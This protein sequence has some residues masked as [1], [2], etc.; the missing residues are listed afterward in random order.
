MYYNSLYGTVELQQIFSDVLWVQ[1]EITGSLIFPVFQ[2]HSKALSQ[3]KE[4]LQLNNSVFV[5]SHS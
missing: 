2:L 1:E 4:S 5:S 3:P